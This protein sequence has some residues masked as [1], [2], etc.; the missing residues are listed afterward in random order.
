M[1]LKTLGCSS[2]TPLFL[3]RRKEW[4][5]VLCIS[6]NR[7]SL[8]L[9]D[10]GVSINKIDMRKED[11]HGES[12]NTTV[13]LTSPPQDARKASVVSP[14]T[15]LEETT[16]IKY[17][18]KV[19][20]FAAD[21]VIDD[22]I[23]S[24]ILNNLQKKL[25][26]TDE[27]AREV[28]EELLE[29]YKIYKQQFNKKVAEQ[30]Y[31]LGEKAEAELNKLQNYYGIKDEYVNSLKQEEEQQEAEKLRQRKQQEAEKL[32]Q[33]DK[34]KKAIRLDREWTESFWTEFW[35]WKG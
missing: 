29:P 9:R 23:E 4:G 8:S 11:L 27:Q 31:P 34:I 22:D 30:G 28:Q 32:R 12:I 19:E 17:R 14:P 1:H 13:V 21:G 10:F 6:L 5:E 16:I 18:Q 35:D 33:L 7:E 15:T 26:L 25:G 2:T 24:H 3:T 20:E